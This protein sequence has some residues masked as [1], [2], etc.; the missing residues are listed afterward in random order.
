MYMVSTWSSQISYILNICVHDLTCLHTKPTT[1][2]LRT[3]NSQIAGNES[4]LAGWLAA[5]V[6]LVR[7]G[8]DSAGWVDGCSTAAN[9]RGS[10]FRWLAGWLLDR[11]WL[12]VVELASRPPL[13]SEGRESAGWLVG[14]R[15]SGFRWLVGWL[16]DRRQ[17]ARVGFP[18]AGW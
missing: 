18:L 15:G 10:G 9:S 1:T 13:I 6:P 17:F 2:E 16:L 5:R 11:P 8:R 3:A 7:R 4:L 12:A 14:S